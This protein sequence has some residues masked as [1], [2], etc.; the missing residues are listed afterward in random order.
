[1]KS[2]ALVV[3]ERVQYYGKDG[4]LITESLKD[5]SKKEHRKEFASLAD[6]FILKMEYF[7]KRKRS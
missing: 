4:K 5:Y 3:N 6:D 7:Q 1:M 2:P